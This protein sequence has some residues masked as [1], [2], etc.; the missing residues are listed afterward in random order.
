MLNPQW[1]DRLATPTRTLQ[2]VVGALT[3]GCLS[4]MAIAV[5][6]VNSSGPV[7]PAEG[8]PLMSYLALSVIP[9]IVVVRGIAGS[10]VA[11]RG[12]GAIA[13]GTFRPAN[14]P[15]KTD[16][17]DDLMPIVQVYATRTIVGGALF[18]G[19]SFFLIIAYLLEGLPVVLAG[20]MVTIV[21]VMLHFPTSGRLAWWIESKS[22]WIDQQRPFRR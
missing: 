8:V 15:P 11:S 7:A 14:P 22:Q 2:I 5:F 4:F 21:C 3:L 19:V 16:K 17:S 6:L 10:V 13:Q 12:C 1:Q 9:V 18:E 20:A